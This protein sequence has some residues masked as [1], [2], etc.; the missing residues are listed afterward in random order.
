MDLEAE[1]AEYKAYIDEFAKTIDPVSI[2]FEARKK[3][4]IKNLWNNLKYFRMINCLCVRLVT[5]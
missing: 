3:S 5:V 2:F 4:S 1:Y